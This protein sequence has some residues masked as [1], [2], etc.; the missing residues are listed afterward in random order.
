[1]RLIDADTLPR[2]GKRGGLVYWR[3]IEN[4]PTIACK[5]CK[6]WSVDVYE[7][8]MRGCTNGFTDDLCTYPDECCSNWEKYEDKE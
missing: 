7:E 2:N 1:M 3:D 4:A 6:Y 5:N 8:N